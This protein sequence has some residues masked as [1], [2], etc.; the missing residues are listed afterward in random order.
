M[1]KTVVILVSVAWFLAEAAG[2]ADAETDAVRAARER[3]AGTW[4]VV[5]VESDGNRAPPGGVIVV[6]NMPDGSWAMVVDG[7]E[8]SRG[9]S[10]MDPLATPAEI[11]IEIT[12][13]D[14]KG[15]K[16]LGIYEVTDARRRLCFRG[17]KGWRPREFSTASGSGAVLVEFERQ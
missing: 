8:A 1:F 14:G 11:D 9:T 3:Y 13:G 5:A 7:R 16:L 4:K 10:S 2:A 17:E 15:T 12:E 6:T